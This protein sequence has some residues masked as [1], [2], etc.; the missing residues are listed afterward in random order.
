MEFSGESFLG[1]GQKQRKTLTTKKDLEFLYN[2]SGLGVNRSKSYT[3]SELVQHMSLECLLETALYL[4]LR[5]KDPLSR[6]PLIRS[7]GQMQSECSLPVVY[8][9]LSSNP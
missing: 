8:I 7:R 6:P 2:A 3:V 9:I 4:A 1:D 5:Y